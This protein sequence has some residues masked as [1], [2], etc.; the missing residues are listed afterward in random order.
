MNPISME[1]TA[2]TRA[3]ALAP[4]A[5]KCRAIEREAL[6]LGALVREG[7]IEKTDV[8]DA[9]CLAGFNNGL[10]AH[11]VEHVVSKGLVGIAT[12]VSAGS[13]LAAGGG[14]AGIGTAA[15][16]QRQQFAPLKFVVEDL[17]PEGL[18]LLAGAPKIGKS[19][20]SLD[21]AIAVAAKR[22]CLG[23]RGAD[24]G[25]VLYL[26]LEDGERRLQRRLKK[27]LPQDVPW[28][29]SLHFATE[30][31]Q[32]DDGVAKIDQWC[33]ACSTPR[34]VV[35]DVLEKFR[36]AASDRNVYGRDYGDLSPLQKLAT[37]RSIAVLV[38]HHTR[39]GAADAS[40]DRISGTLGLPGV[41]DAYL[42]LD[43][44]RSGATLTGSGRD[45]IDVELA[46]HFERDTCRWTVLGR[47]SE[48]RHANERG[49][50]LEFLST[51]A[52][53]ATPT[54]V[55]TELG[56]STVNAKQM[57]H[58]MAKVGEIVRVTRGVY[59]HPDRVTSVTLS[60]A[61]KRAVD[62]GAEG[63]GDKVTEVTR[64]D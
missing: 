45:A 34:L 30:W 64:P 56:T 5:D 32:G 44:G 31:P 57:L 17:L 39:K 35:I 29:P 25:E 43:R 46:V 58:R 1:L 12:L 13:G 51:E 11:T 24:P 36:R 48:V 4:P 14:L 15:S 52:M 33:A 49:R 62:V 37:R 42:V 27:L 6:V 41:A 3:I 59:F 28:P 61:S 23:D 10:D 7:R 2:A 18:T 54:D 9:L 55:S 19:W 53:G 50:V 20:L 8:V 16:L 47:A 26:A 21:M 40:V 38:I 22:S 60:P 63:A